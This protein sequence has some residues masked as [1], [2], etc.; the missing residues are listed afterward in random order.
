MIS[1]DI[2]KNSLNA[3]LSQTGNAKTVEVATETI[4]QFSALVESKP[5]SVGELT[6]GIQIVAQDALNELASTTDPVV[7]KMT[8]SV[9]GVTV[10]ESSSLTSEISTL[11]GKS[12]SNG[13]LKSVT[14][15]ASPKGLQQTL[16][17]ATS[18]NQSQINNLLKKASTLPSVVE[19]A[20]VLSESPTG[21]SGN[22]INQIKSQKSELKQLIGNPEDL[23]KT[24]AGLENSPFNQ[25]A[26]FV[27]NLVGFKPITSIGKEIKNIF[28][29]DAETYL[30][31]GLN[32]IDKFDTS[33]NP[34]KLVDEFGRTDLSN[35][36]S[37]SPLV[38]SNVKITSVPEVI[39]EVGT[40]NGRNTPNSYEFTFIETVEELALELRNSERPFSR[41]TIIPSFDWSDTDF[42]VEGWHKVQSKAKN[43]DK[44]DGVFFHYLI[45]KDGRIQRARPIDID[46]VFNTSK[47]NQTNAFYIMV[48]SGYSV[49]HGTEGA[50]ADFKLTPTVSTQLKIFFDTLF[51]LFPGL[52][53]TASDQ[54]S[55]MGFELDSMIRSVFGKVNPNYTLP[56]KG[57]PPLTRTDIVKARANG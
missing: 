18:A 41:V 14:T 29:T 43:K 13:F 1:K 47:Y 11:T 20:A 56:L 42:S 7:G 2:I 55:E 9:P 6:N 44:T 53:V 27:G 49:P 40:F 37:T 15:S 48:A 25:L 26:N 4:S 8:A 24:P 10:T 33:N 28:D 16:K 34:R 23:L 51:R 21:I 3:A 45:R 35:Q 54:M 36:V 12:A 57:D 17:N 39:G 30:G 19:K 52:P 38:P 31:G 22:L 5:A 50:K 46:P 32:V